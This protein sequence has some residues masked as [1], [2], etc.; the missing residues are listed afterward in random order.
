M[1]GWGLWKKSFD[2]WEGLTAK[3]LEE[4]LKSPLVLEPSG[5]LLAQ[6]MKLKAASEQAAAMM[7]GSLGLPT[8]LDQERT[9]HALNQLESRLMDLEERLT[10][11]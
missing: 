10:P 5:A 4:W 2:A 3:L 11:P 6:V 8:K 9:L 1:L 7:W